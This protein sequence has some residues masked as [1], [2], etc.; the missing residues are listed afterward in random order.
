MPD[1]RKISIP[2]YF[3]GKKIFMTG[4]CGFIGKVLIELLL[5]FCPDISLIYVLVRNKRGRTPEERVKEMLD[6]PLF[7]RLKKEYPGNLKKIIPIVGDIAELNLGLS[8]ESRETLIE[9]VNIIYSIGATVRFDEHIKDAIFTNTRSIRDLALLARESKQLEVFVHV[10]TAYCQVDKEVIEEEI[11]PALADWKNFIRVAEEYDSHYLNILTE[12]LIHPLPNTYVFTKRLAEQVVN[13]IC[14][15]EIP[16]II[17]RPSIVVSSLNQPFPGWTENFNGPIGILA[18][19][20]KGIVRSIYA[21]SDLLAD[22]MPV[23][24]ICKILMVTTWK[25]GLQNNEEK[26]KVEVYNGS[27]NGINILNSKEILAIGNSLMMKFPF[28]KILW[29]PYTSLTT[30]FYY[31]YIRIMLY[32]IL[33]AL[34]LDGLLL[35]F[36]KRAFLMKVQRKIYN[37]SMVYYYFMHREWKIINNK[38]LAIEGE[39]LPKDLPNFA[40][41][42]DSDTYQYLEDVLLGIR[43]YLFKEDAS[44]LNMARIH[45]KRMRVL[46]IVC[47]ILTYITLFYLIIFKFN[48][49]NIMSE[50]IFSLFF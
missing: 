7:D 26:K 9:E 17:Y 50:F 11:Y 15:N 22:Y 29:Y 35:L 21:R 16:A 36:G 12:K 6:L 34:L 20:G 4:G 46:Y 43:Q 24:V 25:K 8:R 1:S 14:D 31:H 39:I 42:L 2:E 33:P 30:C 32:Q 13:N 27:N 38:M 47:N 10:S 40:F 3:R 49:L 19:H 45:F 37:S 18:T 5:R 48:I 23:D 44:S 28:N 41:H